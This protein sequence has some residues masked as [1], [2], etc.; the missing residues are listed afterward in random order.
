MNKACEDWFPSSVEIQ[1][2][3]QSSSPIGFPFS[4]AWLLLPYHLGVAECLRHFGALTSDT[5]IAG[6]SAGA[7][8]VATVACEVPITTATRIVYQVEENLRYFI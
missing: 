4:P 7:L 6:A 5:P 3:L 2:F 8:A 1:E